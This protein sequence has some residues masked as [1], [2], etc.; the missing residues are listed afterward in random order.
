MPK[1][2]DRQTRI[3]WQ[4]G[5]SLTAEDRARRIVDKVLLKHI[6]TPV[7]KKLKDK[8]RNQFPAIHGEELY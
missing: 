8:I 7:A 5:G 4:D 6:P 3:K 2:S 1:V